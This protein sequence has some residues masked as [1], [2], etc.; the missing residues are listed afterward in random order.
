[1]RLPEKDSSTFRGVVT[2][3]QSFIGTAVTLLIGL[4]V[5][6]EAVPGCPEAVLKFAQD[7]VVI[8][9]GSLGVSSGTVSF[10]WNIIFR[11]DVRNY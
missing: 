9:A 8:I 10:L 2:G 1:M 6:V 11:K 7:N 5:S 4:W 3:L